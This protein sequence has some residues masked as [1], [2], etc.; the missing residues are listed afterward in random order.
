VSDRAHVL[1]A[2]DDDDVRHWLAA[3][4]T[5]AG[6]ATTS[7]ASGQAALDHLLDAE[8]RPDLMVLDLDMPG[9]GGMAVLTHARVPVTVPAIVVSGHGDVDRRVAALEAGAVDFVCKPVDARELIARVRTHVRVSARAAEWRDRDPLTGLFNRR[10]FLGRLGDE[11]ARVWQTGSPLAVIFIDLD[12]FK[13]INDRLGHVAGD[14]LLRRVAD[15]LDACLGQPS[16]LGRWGGDEFVVALPGADGASVD[17]IAGRVQD[18]L[19][20]HLDPE[21]VG[22][23]LGIAWLRAHDLAGAATDQVPMALIEAADRAMYDDKA[24][25]SG[26]HRLP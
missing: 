10:G 14:A 11:V 21:P 6:F 24:L 15:A 17:G 4:L 12:N 20:R 13:D 3:T 19:L 18:A 7:V 5:R 8:P 1:I 23:S 22:A 16:I 25:R 9:G 26:L 2:E